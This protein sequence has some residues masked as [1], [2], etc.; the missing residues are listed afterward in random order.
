MRQCVTAG[1]S[2]SKT[3]VDALMPR[4]SVFFVKSLGQAMDCRVKPDNDE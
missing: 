4:R 1:R 3:R 2:A